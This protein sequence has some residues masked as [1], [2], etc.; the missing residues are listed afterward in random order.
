MT[1]IG[2]ATAAGDMQVRVFDAS[3]ALRSAPG[4]AETVYAANQCCLR[5]LR[6]H[7]DSVKKIITEE[8]PDSF[9]SLSEV[10]ILF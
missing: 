8:S 9:L 3:S 1:L 10:R 5:I 2:R 4:D 7:D 6:C